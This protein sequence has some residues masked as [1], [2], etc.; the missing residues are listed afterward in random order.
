[1]ATSK[2]LIKQQDEVFFV[3]CRRFPYIQSGNP[4]CSV[5]IRIPVQNTGKALF[6]AI[7]PISVDRRKPGLARMSRSMTGFEK[8]GCRMIP[9][10]LA[11]VSTNHSKTTNNSESA[12]N[13]MAF[14]CCVL[15]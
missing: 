8:I 7:V 10:D 11:A 13:M 4:R 1:M 12:I 5:Y 2:H 3:C 15:I 14:I 9:K 6:R